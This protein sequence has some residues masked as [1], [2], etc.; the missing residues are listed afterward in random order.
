MA[1]RVAPTLVPL[2]SLIQRT[3]PA[4]ATSS[5]RWGSPGKRVSTARMAA[6]GR[7]RRWPMASAARA[8]AWWWRPARRMAATGISGASPCISH[9]APRW[10][11]M[12]HSPAAGARVVKRSRA[13]TSMSGQVAGSSA[14]TT[15]WRAPRKTPSLAA[16]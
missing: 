1:A 8:L 5:L 6:S 2:E 3:P 14:L 9:S 10:R 16:R 11:P 4:C 12:P 15:A 13:G 7:P